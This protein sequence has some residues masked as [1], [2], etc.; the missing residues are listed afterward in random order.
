ME[1]QVE[2]VGECGGVCRSFLRPVLKMTYLFYPYLACVD[3]R[4]CLRSSPIRCILSK[5]RG[6]NR[7]P[8]QLRRRTLFFVVTI[9]FL[10]T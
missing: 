9:T 3:S 4:I 5:E 10:P 8:I 2:D 1:D 7:Q 6:H